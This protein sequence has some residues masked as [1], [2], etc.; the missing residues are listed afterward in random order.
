M[1]WKLFSADLKDLWKYR[2]IA[3]FFL[4]CLLSFQRYWHF[5]FMQIRSVMSSFGV[6][7]KTGK[8]SINN[9]SKTIEAVLLELGT[10]NVH[11]KRNKMIPLNLLPWQQFCHLCRLNK[12]WNS[13]P[14]WWL[15]LRQYEN[16]VWSKQDPLSHFKGCKWGHLFFFMT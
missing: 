6:Q 10:T 13:Q 16:Y 3:F 9:I 11:H 8:N 5:S 2:W 14:I 15:E 4:K 7:L 12:N 1:T